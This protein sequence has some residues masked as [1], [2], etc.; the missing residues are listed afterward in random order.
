[1]FCQTRIIDKTDKTVKI[2]GDWVGVLPKCVINGV[3][4]GVINRP[5]GEHFSKTTAVGTSRPMTTRAL[6]VEKGQKVSIISETGLYA[7][8]HDGADCFCPFDDPF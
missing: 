6:R 1:M 5:V 7:V 8:T 4:S 2:R 3:I